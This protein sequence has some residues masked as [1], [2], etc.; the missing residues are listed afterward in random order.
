M[1][2]IILALCSFLAGCIVTG[3]INRIHYK[4]IYDEDSKF[5][6]KLGVFD[7]KS[8]EREDGIGWKADSEDMRQ[9]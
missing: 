3:I 9:K 8:Y 7:G 4:T 6:Y 2:S 1:I 5:W